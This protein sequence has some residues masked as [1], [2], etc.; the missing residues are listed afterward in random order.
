MCRCARDKSLRILISARA[1]TA[2]VQYWLRHHERS[3]TLAA[4][5][6]APNAANHATAVSAATVT[7]TAVAAAVAAT[8][9]TTS[10]VTIT[11]VAVAARPDHQRADEMGPRA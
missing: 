10:A 4:A 3:A 11:P 6:A 5:S 1:V 7:D 8:A 9:M 2:P